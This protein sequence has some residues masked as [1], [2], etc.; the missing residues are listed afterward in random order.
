MK[1]ILFAHFAGFDVD[2]PGDLA[3]SAWLVGETTD[4]KVAEDMSKKEI[5]DF[6]N[7]EV[8]NRFDVCEEYMT[9]EEK[10]EVNLFKKEFKTSLTSIRI[11]G[12]K[13]ETIATLYHNGGDCY[14]ETLKIEVIK[15]ED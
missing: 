3:N 14:Y 2:D 10:E 6:I 9:D 4:P 8:D 5:D 12:T 1:Y 13:L 15:L 7:Q 11:P